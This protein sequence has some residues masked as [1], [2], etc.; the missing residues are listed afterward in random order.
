[1][2]AG[3]LTFEMRWL[4]MAE[5]LEAIRETA[6]QAPLQCRSGSVFDR[7]PMYGP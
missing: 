7:S 2:L 3:I 1:M 5:A 4:G 6:S